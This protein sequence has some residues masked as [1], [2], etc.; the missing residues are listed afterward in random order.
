LAF[1]AAFMHV[2]IF[3]SQCYFDAMASG[4]PSSISKKALSHYLKGIRLLRERFA[5]EDNRAKLSIT[6]IAAIMSLVGHA[7]LAGDFE[8][9]VHHMEGLLKIVILRGGVAS[10]NE[11]PK[12]LIEVLR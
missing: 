11:S 9:A 5:S 4:T 12:I 6:T 2:M 7:M 10:F 1:D 8:S 3:T